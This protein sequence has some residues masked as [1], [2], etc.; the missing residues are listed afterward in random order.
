MVFKKENEV[1]ELVKSKYLPGFEIISLEDINIKAATSNPFF[2]GMNILA[3]GKKLK[4]LR[5]NT[6]LKELLKPVS[7]RTGIKAELEINQ[8]ITF[9]P[10]KSFS[11]ENRLLNVDNIYGS[12]ESIDPVFINFGLKDVKIFKGDLLGTI[13]IQTVENNV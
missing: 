10:C 8:F 11:G 6:D 12:I 3:L 1:V 5:D 4:G 13:L 7:I 2:H 9:V